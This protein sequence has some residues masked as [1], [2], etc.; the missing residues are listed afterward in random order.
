[1]TGLSVLSQ[2]MGKTLVLM[3]SLRRFKTNDIQSRY[4]A[5]SMADSQL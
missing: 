5:S 2:D 4:C 1:M 3:T